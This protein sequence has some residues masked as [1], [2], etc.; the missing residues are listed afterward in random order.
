[1]SRE[2]N[3]YD[4]LLA[5]EVYTLAPVS[6]AKSQTIA[7]GDLLV[8]STTDGVPGATFSKATANPTMGKLT[9][10]GA[11]TA[12]SL[13]DYIYAIAAQ[14]ITTTASAVGVATAYLAGIFNKSKVGLPSGFADGNKYALLARGIVLREAQ[15]GTIS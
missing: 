5:G 8:C 15:S 13:T 10:T 3:N 2:V 12:V 14:D 11:V 1:M 6:I 9:V 4:G 7:R